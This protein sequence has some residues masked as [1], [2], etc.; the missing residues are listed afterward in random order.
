MKKRT[1]DLDPRPFDNEERETIDAL[2]RAMDQDALVSYLTPE[3]QCRASGSGPQNT[4]NPPKASHFRC[5]SPNETWP[6]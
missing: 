2:D 6:R 1:I 4:M 3:T 5:A